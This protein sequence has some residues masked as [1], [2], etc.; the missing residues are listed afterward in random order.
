METRQEWA[1]KAPQIET[2]S[3]MNSL[4]NEMDLSC[5]QP[6]GRIPR[7]DHAI[8]KWEMKHSASFSFIRT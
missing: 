4:P 5:S 3:M 2:E 1:E 8:D 7:I 6:H